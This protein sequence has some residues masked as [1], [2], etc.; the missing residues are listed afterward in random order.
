MDEK[1]IPHYINDPI[2]NAQTAPELKLYRPKISY[3]R[4]SMFIIAHVAVSEIAISI[5]LLVN[6][7]LTYTAFFEYQKYLLLL[8]FVLFMLTLKYTLIWFIRL[9]QKYAKSETRLRC[10]MTPSCS[11]YS[12]LALKKYGVIRGIPKM[13]GRFKRC[14]FPGEI[15]YP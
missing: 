9:Y 12:I 6:N 13:I 3:L 10:N 8:V 5:W 14:G 2:V 1:K 7:T 11:E 15:D 4:A